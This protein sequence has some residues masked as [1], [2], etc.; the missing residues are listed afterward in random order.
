MKAKEVMSQP[1][2]FVAATASIM[3][4]VR[5]M[6]ENKISG[7]PVVDGAGGLVGVVTEGDFLRR[8]ETGTQRRRP[9]WIEF[10]VGPGRLAQEYVHTSGRRVD[11]VMTTD[12]HTVA[13]D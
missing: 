13:E 2:I 10:L 9:R 8:I 7:L 6:L 12:V 11:D 1:V 5:M 4:A 3:D